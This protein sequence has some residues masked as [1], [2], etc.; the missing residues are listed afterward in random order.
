MRV[1]LCAIIPVCALLGQTGIEV[2]Q[3]DVKPIKDANAT[4]V[5]KKAPAT[6]RGLARQLL[7]NAY[8]TIGSLTPAAQPNLLWR[9]A[10]CY[11][12]LDKTK[13]ADILNQAFADAGSLQGF[14]NP[15]P[16]VQS[17]IAVSMSDLNTARAAEMVRAIPPSA[18]LHV[19]SYDPRATAVNAIVGRMLA[20]HDIDA[21][22]ELVNSLGGD[23]A[24]PYESVGSILGS[25]ES[26][27]D[28]RRVI[29]FGNAVSAYQTRP[30]RGFGQMLANHWSQLPRSSVIQALDSIVNTVLAYKS[31]DST[32]KITYTGKKGSAELPT[33]QDVELFDVIEPLNACEPAKSRELFETHTAL[34]HAA[35]EFPRGVNWADIGG[36]RMSMTQHG[37]QPGNQT[38]DPKQ[39]EFAAGVM[40]QRR[41]VDL[42]GSDLQAA[43]DQLAT[44]TNPDLRA[45]IMIEIASSHVESA[46]VIARNLLDKALDL[47]STPKNPEVEYQDLSH[48]FDVAQ[49]L[50]DD[51][52]TSG[53]LKDSFEVALQLYKIDTD[54]DDPNVMPMDM[55]PSVDAYRRSVREAEELHKM[56]AIAD[57]DGIKN[58]DLLAIAQVALAAALLDRHFND[59]T[60]SV[61]LKKQNR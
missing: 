32:Y 16:G 38:P 27:D 15:G 33:E 36:V 58:P 50:K 7:D 39:A 30:A 19:W 40:R 10:D 60:A 61:H 14:A 17:Q 43:I 44:V 34:K 5:E 2:K 53:V 1:L 55:W 57:L 11:T 47:L 52:L 56:K 29:V 41:I 49:K 26:A 25:L 3:T 51:A 42:A 8:E 20:K 6:P 31:D 37:S 45:G 24:F 28:P 46:P 18:D 23:G 12:L 13:A 54:P 4:R 22:I 21:A 59:S 9:I 35:D 48:A